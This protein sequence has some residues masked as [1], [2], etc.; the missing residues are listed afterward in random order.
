MYLIEFA[1]H[2]HRQVNTPF[3]R[4]SIIFSSVSYNES[5]M[6]TMAYWQQ[7]YKWNWLYR[8][9]FPAN[10]AHNDDSLQFTDTS[11][12]TGSFVAFQFPL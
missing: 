4:E 2:L 5:S 10:P 7:K 9:S 12:G 3:H 1:A 8:V 6:H 11:C